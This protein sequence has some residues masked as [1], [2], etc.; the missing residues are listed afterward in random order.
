MGIRV[1][2]NSPLTRLNEGEVPAMID[3]AESLGLSLQFDPEITPRDDGD[4][5]PLNLSATPEGVANM[6][7]E[8]NARTRRAMQADS[9]PVNPPSSSTLKPGSKRLKACGA[10][11]TN[12]TIDPFGNVYPCVQFRRAVG[13][14][15][16]SSVVEIWHSSKSLQEVRELAEEAYLVARSEGLKQFCMGVNEL[17]TGDPLKTHQVKR[18]INRIFDRVNWEKDQPREDV[19]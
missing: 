12:L 8:T 17:H 13:N 2:L 14:I 9:I 4:M 16:D 10:G 6:V 19:A 11:S 5:A 3:L 7:R 15:H 1:K 18:D